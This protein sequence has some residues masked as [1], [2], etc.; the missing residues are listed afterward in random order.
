MHKAVAVICHAYPDW[1]TDQGKNLVSDQFYHGLSPSLWDALGFTMAEMPEREQASASFDMLYT[2][3]K[4]MEA[5]QPSHPHQSR[6]G[7]TD[8][9]RDKYR[10][11]PSPTGWVAMLED[12][13]LLPPDP[14]SP[15]SEA[16]KPDIE[17]LS[18]RMSQAMNHHQREE[19]CCFVF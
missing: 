19:H 12:E 15:D 17:G 9:Y 11:C 10:R 3:A 14:E 1:V 2:L 16:P 5:C 6:S 7:S 4:K 18:L 8:A 13:E